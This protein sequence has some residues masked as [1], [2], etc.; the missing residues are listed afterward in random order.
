V[1]GTARGTSLTGEKGVALHTVEHFLAAVSGLG[2]TNLRVDVTGEEIPILDGSS[3]IFVQGF[4]SVGVV[5]QAKAVEPIRVTETIVLED[6]A[7]RMRVEPCDRLVLEVVVSFPKG[8][9]ERQTQIFEWT[10]GAFEKEL[11]GARTFC[12]EEEVEMLRQQGLI[13]GASLD[14]GLVYNQWGVLNGPLRYENEIAR[15]KTLDLLG[16]LA[17]LNRPLVAKVTVERGGHKYHVMLAKAIQEQAKKQNSGG[18]MLDVLEVQKILPHRPPFLLVDRILEVEP[19]KR[20]V[21]I[22]NVTINEDFFRGHFPGAPIMPGVLILEAMAQVGG[23][24]FLYGAAPGSLVLFGAADNVRWRKPVVP[25]DQLRLEVELTKVRG[26]LIMASGKA[27]VDGQ[28][29]A[30]ADIT[31]M[32]ADAAKQGE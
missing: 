18:V 2:I 11:E 7:T 10:E 6:G 31:C 26:R 25:G 8:G 27:L 14:C 24:A 1:S 28:V 20:A 30:E 12:L 19:Q 3:R 16:D 23:V 15:H 21:G 32:R 5:D 9:V 22:K 17:L 29:V 4:R 13:K